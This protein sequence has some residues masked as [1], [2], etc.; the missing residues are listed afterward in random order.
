[1]KSNMN[2]LNIAFAKIITITSILFF[3]FN[4]AEAVGPLDLHFKAGLSTPNDK[5]GKV[6]SDENL[7]S[8]NIASGNFFTENAALGYH[9]GIGARI[10]LSDAM[11][12]VGGVEFHRFPRSE[13]RIQDPESGE[14]YKLKST[15]N[16]FPI[17][18]GVNLVFI[19]TEL[20]DIYA[21]GGFAY[22]YTSNSVDYVTEESDFSLPLDLSPDDSRVGYF[23][24]AGTDLN[25][26]LLTLNLELKY[27]HINLIGK[28]EG[29][30]NKQFLAIS[31]GLVL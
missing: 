5:I 31:L 22:N 4:S 28:E 7:E 30:L 25:L 19:N 17:Y 10:D 6:Y 14:I 1:M 27:Q 26:V 20:L 21:T 16:V 11:Q 12:F 2:N 23:L 13:F 3:N 29:E 24:G 9:L 15:Q 18:A 8:A